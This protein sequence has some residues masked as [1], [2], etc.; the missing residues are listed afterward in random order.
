VCITG[1]RYVD[2]AI[3]VAVVAVTAGAA[4]PTLVPAIGSTAFNIGVGAALGATTS[5][6]LG[7][8]PLT[9]ALI[10]GATGGFFGGVDPTGLS[11]AGF[12][13]AVATQVA[14]GGAGVL[15]LDLITPKAPTF[16]TPAQATG[17]VA[18]IQQLNLQP[19]SVTGSGGPSAT[20]SLAEAIRRTKDRKLTQGDVSDLSVDVS[21]FSPYGLQLAF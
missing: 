20:R 5:A 16:A 3:G 9:G 18:Q 4:A 15:A 2:L 12:E 10:G 17:A 19:L 1:N 21:S 14:I 6:A 13:Q 11:A 8:D 7:N